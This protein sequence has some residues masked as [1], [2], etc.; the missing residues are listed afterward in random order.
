MSWL[1]RDHAAR[2]EFD[3]NAAS[4]GEPADQVIGLATRADAQAADQGNRLTAHSDGSGASA[5]A[6]G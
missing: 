4:V 5:F 2:F 1:K 3:R 6:G